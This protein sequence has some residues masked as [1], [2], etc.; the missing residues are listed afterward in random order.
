MYFVENGGNGKSNAGGK[1]TGNRGK[2]GSYSN[3]MPY[4][5]ATYGTGLFSNKYG[6]GGSARLVQ[7]TAYLDPAGPRAIYIKYLGI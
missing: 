3:I 1:G 6:M 7:G 4:P 2:D 5:S